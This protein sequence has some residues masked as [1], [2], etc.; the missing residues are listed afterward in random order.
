MVGTL[1]LS[2]QDFNITMINMLWAP[3]EKV[4]NM[5]EQMGTASRNKY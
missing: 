3:K 4:D 2:D 5:Q 1:E